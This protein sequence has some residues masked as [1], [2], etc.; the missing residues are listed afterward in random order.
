MLGKDG[1]ARLV[2]FGEAAFDCDHFGHGARG[3]IDGQL[4]RYGAS[5]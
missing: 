4:A 5:P 3:R 1:Q 2:D